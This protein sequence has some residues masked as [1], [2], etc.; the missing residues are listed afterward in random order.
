MPVDAKEVSEFGTEKCETSFLDEDDRVI[1]STTGGPA[2]SEAS[3]IR[4]ALEANRQLTAKCLCSH[5]SYY[6]LVEQLE[7][8]AEEEPPL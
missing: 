3:D 8:P 1:F 7:E 2:P 4:A 6:A 5:M